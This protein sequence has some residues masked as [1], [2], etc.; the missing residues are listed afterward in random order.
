MRART[1]ARPRF[2]TSSSTRDRSVAEPSA[3]EI[4]VVASSPSIARSSSSERSVE[5]RNRCAW[6]I[7]IAAHSAS[8]VIVSTSRSSNSP[9]S[10]SVR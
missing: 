4:A 6:S 2:T 1:S 10:F 9:P 7:A 8:T 5:R 3:R